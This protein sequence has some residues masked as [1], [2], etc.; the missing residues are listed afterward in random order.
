M[1]VRQDRTPIRVVADL[2]HTRLDTREAYFDQA[3]ELAGLLAASA[4]GDVIGPLAYEGGWRLV[5]LRERT[6]AAIED[7]ALR[8]RATT[9]LVEDALA[10]HL[11]GRVHWYGQH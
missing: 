3:S 4:P 8:E 2:G 7:T 10:R 5:W 9:Q 1:L 11:A 6:P